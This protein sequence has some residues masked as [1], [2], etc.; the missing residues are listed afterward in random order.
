M[1][2]KLTA[3]IMAVLLVLSLT[4]CS[5]S[6][7]K[8]PAEEPDI[9]TEEQ[10]AEEP[11]KEEKEQQPE[12]EPAPDMQTPEQSAVETATVTVYY[13]NVDATAFESSEV[14]IGSLSP[15]AVLSALVSTGTLTVD[16]EENSFTMTVVDDKE[17]IELDL[18]DAFAAY[19]SNMGSTG[20]YYTVGALCNTFLDAYDCEQ[21]RITVE[22][23]SL[24]TGHAEYPGYLSRFE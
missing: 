4:A 1:K 9:Q 17:S 21:I 22:G 19:V 14:Q 5:G 2:A 24:S 7:D 6:D 10:E 12:E 23:D 11:L 18:N 8:E 15:E 13:S 16:V 3:G 20:E